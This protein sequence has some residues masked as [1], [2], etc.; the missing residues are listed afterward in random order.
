[1]A[2]YCHASTGAGVGTSTSGSTSAGASTSASASSSTQA[3]S[4]RRRGARAPKRLRCA[5]PP[6]WPAN[7]NLTSSLYRRSWL[8]ACV[9]DAR[10]DRY[11]SRAQR[12][13]R[14][15]MPATALRQPGTSIGLIVQR[16]CYVY[17][18]T[19]PYMRCRHVTISRLPPTLL[20]A[21]RARRRPHVRFRQ[22]GSCRT[23]A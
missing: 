2:S 7:A 23:P 11:L 5:L 1:M 15:E 8:R 21:A 13:R 17:M 3:L 10:A 6:C 16:Q 22:L 18:H 12:E 19:R 14:L 20:R 9:R 4:G